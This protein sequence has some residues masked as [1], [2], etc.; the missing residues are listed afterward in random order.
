MSHTFTLIQIKTLTTK[1]SYGE[2]APARSGQV[3]SA[4]A[5]SMEILLAARVLQGLGA[6][7]PRVASM[8]IIRDM[9]SGRQMAQII[10]FV[11]FVF[12]LAPVFAPSR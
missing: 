5:P 4:L 11:I 9:F 10:S 12:T 8:A 6:A 7:G 1:V 3:V 2:I